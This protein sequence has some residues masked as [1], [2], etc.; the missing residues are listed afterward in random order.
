MKIMLPEKSVI[1]I[2]NGAWFVHQDSLNSIKIN[3]SNLGKEKI[4]LN[5]RLI[6]EQ[7]SLKTKRE[8]NFED[9]SGNKYQIKFDAANV[10][11]GMECYILR[12]GELIKVFRTRY[13]S[14]KDHDKRSLIIYLPI[15]IFTFLI[16][17]FNLSRF[18]NIPSILLVVII[19]YMIKKPGKM[20]IEE[21][22][23]TMA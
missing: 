7:R 10:L 8:Y 12:E 19:Y 5:D 20:V 6:S 2:K 22:I 21:E 23:K 13:L 3:C 15:I 1:S 14:G 16:E 11:K 17:Y 18:F 4:Y 9:L